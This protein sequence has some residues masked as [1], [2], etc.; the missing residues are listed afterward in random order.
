[1]G[2]NFIIAGMIFLF[3]PFISLFD[4]LPDVIGYALI[5]YGLSKIADV[6]LKVMEAKRRMTQ[7]LYVGAGRLAFMLMALFMEFDSTLTLVFAFSFA[8]LEFFFM[9]PA[10]NMFFESLEYSRMRFAESSSSLSTKAENA[11]KMTPIFIIVRAVASVV[12]ELTSLKTDYGYVGDETGLDD[13]GVIRIALLALCALVAL[14]FG[15]VWLSMVL[16]YLKELRKSSAFWA[17]MKEKYE[18][19]VLT[20]KALAMQRSV[21]RF[22]SFTFASVFFLT[23]ISIDGYYLIPEFISALLM[24]F[25]FFFSKRY[26]AEYKKVITACFAAIVAGVLA[27]VMLFRYSSELGYVLYAYKAEGF[28]GY[29]LPYIAIAAVFYALLI[30]LAVKGKAAAKNMVEDAV[31]VRGTQ[32]VRRREIDEHRKAELCKYIDRLF[33]L[34]C[35]TI[36]GG[37]VFMAL[38]PWFD[39]AWTARTVLA[40][41]TAIYAYNIMCDI[42]EEAE[43]AV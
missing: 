20:D 21:K 9:I 36:G 32:D 11:A 43:K 12:P 33:V 13:S 38:M 15:A 41:I 27:Y 30:W 14:V 8:T 25:A 10:F 7:V 37:A 17:Y 18:N 40:V 34:E 4:I 26:V 35:I 19:T 3:N 5:V 39:L 22:W 42:N 23:C 28:W 29:F 6:E 16:S 24:F 1:M 31:G 2:I